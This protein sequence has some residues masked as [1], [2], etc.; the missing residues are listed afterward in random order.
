MSVVIIG[1]STR[2]TAF[3]ADRAGLRPWCIDLFA[4]ADL[5]RRFPVRRVPIEKYPRGLIAAMRDA[6]EGPV[7]YTG[8]LENH[9]E[10]I[11]QIDRPR[12]ADR[13]GRREYE[14]GGRR[15]PRVTEH[16]PSSGTA[17]DR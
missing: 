11:G 6:P 13:Q 16:E 9:P 4:D 17:I 8:G 12:A 1:A 3:S 2:A 5:E 14:H 10:L 15:R 7:I